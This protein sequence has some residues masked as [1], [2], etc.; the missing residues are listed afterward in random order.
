MSRTDASTEVE[1]YIA[2]PAQAL[3]YKIGELTI[4]RLRERSQA[5]LGAAFDV[6]DFHDQVLMSGALPLA[7]LESKIDAWI[8]QRRAGGPPAN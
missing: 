6:R 7:V 2:N 4:R 1:R 3:A 8:A 5:A